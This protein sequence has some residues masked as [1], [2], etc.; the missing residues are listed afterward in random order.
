[1]YAHITVC[2][3][4]IVIKK[5][6]NFWQNLT[7][8]V[9]NFSFE[10]RIFNAI[11]IISMLVL[12]IN[13]LVNYFINLPVSALLSAAIV[14]AVGIIYYYSRVKGKLTTSIIIFGI[15]SN[16]AFIINYYVNSGI[17]GP[18]LQIFVLSFFL[19]I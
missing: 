9:E 11:C 18:S 13:G 7:G 10:A 12:S 8:K 6:I 17:N 2:S 1:M 14:I 3:Y 15:S 4:L 5:L 16:L 19:I